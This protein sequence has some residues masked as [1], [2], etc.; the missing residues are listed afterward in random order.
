VP[1]HDVQ[2]GAILAGKYRVERVLGQGGMGVVVEATQLDLARRVALKFVRKTRLSESPAALTRFEREARTIARL[3]GAHVVQVYDVGRLDHGEPFIVMELLSGEDLSAVLEREQRL[4]VPTA[5]DYVLQACEAMAEAHVAGVVHRDLKPANLFLTRGPDGRAL[6]KV[7]D[8]GI[9]KLIAGETTSLSLTSG[10]LGSPLYMSPEQLNSS[11][12]VDYRSDIWSLGA[13]LYELVSGKPAFHADGLPQVCTRVMLGTPDPIPSSAKVPRELEA[14]IL[15]CLDKS[16]AGRPLSV[17]DLALSLAPFGRQSSHRSAEVAVRIIAASHIPHGNLPRAF[18]S[19][20]PPAAADPRLDGATD[21]SGPPSSV[22]R[23]LNR[24]DDAPERTINISGAPPGITQQELKPLVSQTG[25]QSVTEPK[26]QV[27]RAALLGGLAL[28]VA[29]AT[30][31]GLRLGRSHAGSVA[32]SDTPSAAAPSVAPLAAASEPA[33]LPSASASASIVSATAAAA[34]VP[35]PSAI[36]KPGVA[37][38]KV[39]PAPRPRAEPDADELLK[40][41]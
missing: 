41:R 2:V 27:S 17:A 9:S 24:A 28:I 31:L 3:R 10:V 16:P 13:I 29:V 5:V 35:A 39:R 34:P 30:L 11:K 1:E 37:A 19:M 4:A 25:M 21:I 40:H 14:M 26:S 12:Q 6:L 33:P 38:R 32:S 36:T 18:D 22:V 15:T 20:P 7:L 8:F 23:E